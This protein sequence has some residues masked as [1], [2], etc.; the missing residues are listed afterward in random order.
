MIYNTWF[1]ILCLIN[2]EPIM[3]YD[4]YYKIERI[5]DNLTIENWYNK[6]NKILIKKLYSLIYDYDHIILDKLIDRSDLLYPSENREITC[7]NTNNAAP[8]N[9]EFQQSSNSELNILPT[10]INKIILKIILPENFIANNISYINTVSY[11]Y[12]D[13]EY[14][15]NTPIEVTINAYNNEILI[16]YTTD[17]YLFS[18]IKSIHDGIYKLLTEINVNN[19]IIKN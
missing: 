2:I 15:K 16:N 14:L 18:N 4:N 5:N 7:Y 1:D 17:N 3:E 19:I 9:C 8:S 13:N 11:N 10:Q 12:F 6:V